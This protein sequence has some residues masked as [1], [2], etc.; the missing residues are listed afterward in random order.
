MESSVK[1]MYAKGAG[2]HSSEAVSHSND[3]LSSTRSITYRSLS[4]FREFCR[5][6]PSSSSSRVLARCSF[7]VTS[8]ES[9]TF[10]ASLS[11]PHYHLIASHCNT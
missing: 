3:G 11:F 4:V 2:E 5:F 7:L 9:R 6:V 10:A 8:F 1:E